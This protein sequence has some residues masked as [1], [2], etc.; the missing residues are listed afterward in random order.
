MIKAI[1]F[2]AAGI[3]Y[4]RS[5]HTEDFALELLIKGKFSTDPTQEQF[6]RQLELRSQANQGLIT[7]LE[8]WDH[9][10]LI[11]GVQNPQQRDDFSTE[12]MNYSN[13]IIPVPGAR[14]TL[15][16]LKKK[17]FL[18]GIIT[19]TMYPIEWKMRRLE[20]AG[21]AEFIDFVACSTE[22]G[23]HKPDP[24][25]YAHAIKQGNLM[26]GESVFVGHL[27]TEL[28]GA[29]RAGM[30]TIAID[31]DLEARADHYCQSIS[32]LLDLPILHRI[33]T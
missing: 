27:G 14:E 31:H 10:L 13:D 3:L 26:N 9:F 28:E 21:V 32:E 6:T 23:V 15:A 11:R 24:A 20:K 8:Y 17:G 18:L 16:G 12:I 4:T 7:P 33:Q 30:F 5:G 1:F 25:I 29:R 2:D 22:L 19:D